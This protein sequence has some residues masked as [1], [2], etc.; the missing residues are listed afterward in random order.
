MAE[1][2]ECQNFGIDFFGKRNLLD[3]IFWFQKAVEKNN[4]L[5]ESFIYL[6]RCYA[7]QLSLDQAIHNFEQAC[8]VSQNE[9]RAKYWLE[10][11][12][13]RGYM[14]DEYPDLFRKIYWMER[15]DEDGHIEHCK[16]LYAAGF[17]SEAYEGIKHVISSRSDVSA[18]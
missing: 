17:L 3:A 13:Q 6:G 16:E 2:T 1:A 12:H 18:T 8:Q 9:E 7:I 14:I 15:D 10:L 11:A 5:S 4:E